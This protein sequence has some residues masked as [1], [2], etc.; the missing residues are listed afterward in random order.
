MI[1]ECLKCEVDKPESEFYLFTDKWQN[2]QYLSARCK[3]CH[4]EYKKEN[5]VATVRNRK[6]EK[7][8]LRYGLSYEEWEKLRENENFS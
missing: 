4:K 1:K 3:T 2:K 8:K 7:L 6:A 5:P